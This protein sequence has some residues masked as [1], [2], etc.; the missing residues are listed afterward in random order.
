MDH[1]ILKPMKPVALIIDDERDICFLLSN[2]LRN[3][4][5]DVQF[6]NSITEG[7]DYLQKINPNLLFLDNHLPDGFGIDFISYV[8]K[9]HAQT[10]IVMVTA[11]DTP[12]DR[13]R[14]LEEGADIFIGKPFSAA[15]IKD[16]LREVYPQIA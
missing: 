7:K 8:K 16:A 6:V 12:E 4:N 5:V 9:E 1:D 11:H 3:S 10:K 14:A 2:I 15:E 13:K